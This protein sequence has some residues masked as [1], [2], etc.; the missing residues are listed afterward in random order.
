MVSTSSFE[1]KILSK[2][3]HFRYKLQCSEIINKLK[4]YIEET[5]KINTYKTISLSLPMSQTYKLPEEST[6]TVTIWHIK[7]S[8]LST[9]PAKTMYKT[10]I[11]IIY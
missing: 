10:P 5:R 11:C 2:E 3:N 7:F 6:V 9:K 8:F 1:Y 4:L